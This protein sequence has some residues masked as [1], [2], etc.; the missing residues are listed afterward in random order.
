MKGTFKMDIFVEQIVKKEPTGADWAK[1]VAVGLGMGVIMAVGLFIFLF[2]WLSVIGLAL[3][4]GAVWLGWYLIT[5]TECEYE[6]IVT[7]GEIDIDKIIAKRKRVRLI[8]AK[9]SAFEAF[10]EYGNAPDIDS[11]VTVV[12]ASGIPETAGENGEV[13]QLST[14]YADLKHPTAGAVRLIFT[15]EQKVIDALTPF[16]SRQLKIELAKNK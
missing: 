8:T 9:A 11:G 4:A 1:R 13:K 7:N 14:Y 3:F 2:T 15:P 10:G 12:S 16:F 6:Y 5:N